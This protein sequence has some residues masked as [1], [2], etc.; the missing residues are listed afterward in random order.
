MWQSRRN[1]GKGARLTD[2]VGAVT[3][4]FAVCRQCCVAGGLA[5]CAPDECRSRASGFDGL[6][7]AI[8]RSAMPQL[9]GLPPPVAAA[10]GRDGLRSG[11]R[12]ARPSTRPSR[13]DAP[14]R[15][16][17]R[18]APLA[19]APAPAGAL[20]AVIGGTGREPAARQCARGHRRDE[21]ARWRRSIAG[22]SDEQDFNAVAARETIESDKPSG[23]RGTGAVLWW[24]QPT[25]LPQR[26]G[27]YRAEHRG[28]CAGHQPTRVG[29]QVYSRSAIRLTSRRCGLQALCARPTWRRR[30]SWSRGGPE[31][32]RKG[33]DPDGDG[34]A[35]AWDPR[36]FRAALQ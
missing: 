30:R 4:R 20:S 9:P 7:A 32:D 10:A 19:S 21:R 34:F 25:A 35:C 31:R 5:A 33:L 17:S 1:G 3:M 15:R 8:G 6:S 16:W 28:I 12:A 26:A 18:P 36:P 2:W 24:S 14:A 27:R 29:E 13:R 23:S 11:A 22:I